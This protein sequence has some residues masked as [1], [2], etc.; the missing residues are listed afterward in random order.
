[1]PS[2][3]RASPRRFKLLEKLVSSSSI[4]T[5]SGGMLVPGLC[6]GEKCLDIRQATCD[7]MRMSPIETTLAAGAGL[8]GGVSDS[9]G[10]MALGAVCD[11]VGD[12]G[13]L[14]D[15]PGACC[16][17]YLNSVGACTAAWLSLGGGEADGGKGNVLL[18][19][20]SGCSGS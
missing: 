19:Y 9:V 7:S 20:L 13:L 12:V 14:W 10:T 16:A 1:M 15:M 6:C 3:T 4:M 17:K 18:A 8:S 11:K 2:K 5:N